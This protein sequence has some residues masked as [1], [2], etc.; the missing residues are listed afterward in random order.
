MLEKKLFSFEIDNL[1]L[2]NALHHLAQEGNILINMELLEQDCIRL[3][4]SPNAV[5][6][7]LRLNDVTIRQ[8]LDILMKTVEHRYYWQQFEDSQIINII[9]AEKRGD[10]TYLPNLTVKSFQYEYITPLS[11]MERLITDELGKRWLKR[12]MGHIEAQPRFNINLQDATVRQILNTM[13]KATFFDWRYLGTKFALWGM[14]PSGRVR[15]L[16]YT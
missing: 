10:N 13:S 8:A 11:C 5:G 16:F 12:V 9:P 6:I 1:S 3:E 14:T 7:S 2:G 15:A 4:D